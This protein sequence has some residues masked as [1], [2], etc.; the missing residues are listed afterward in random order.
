MESYS[1]HPS[2]PELLALADGEVEPARAAA[3]REHLAACRECRAS[4]ERL[5]QALGQYIRTHH[6]SL[7]AALPCLAGPRA[8]L[9]AQLARLA[10][11]ATHQ[12]R[13]TAAAL[14]AAALV[15]TPVLLKQ[16]A[17]RGR[18]ESLI[19]A[20]PERRL[21]PGATVRLSRDEVCST[22]KTKNRTV[23]VD[24][25]RKVFEAYGIRS[26]EPDAYEIDYLITPALGGADDIRNLWPQAYGHTV[27]NAT[28]KDELEDRL[29]DL[30]CTG[31]LDL[32]TAQNEIATDW[33]AAYKKYFHTDG[34]RH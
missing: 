31:S 32:G 21:T 16:I 13:W 29:R 19:F 15:L 26:A 30:V 17:E 23:P 34:P 24:L 3:M 9:K 20:V 1:P 8:L 12:W 27:W 18:D 33:I 2:G 5:E 28:V 14:L 7:G 6:E 22:E 11:P 4:L 10:A 25:R